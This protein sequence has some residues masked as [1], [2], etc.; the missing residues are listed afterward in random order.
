MS[1]IGSNWKK[2]LVYNALYRMDESLRMIGIS[3]EQLDEQ[4]LWRRPNGASNSVANLLLHLCGNIRQ[5]II[6][7]LG[8]AADVR[9]RDMEF[10]QTGEK[11]AAELLEQL[12]SVI[13]EAKSVISET[14]EDEFLRIREVQGFNMSGLG[15][16][17]HVV[18]HLSYHTGQ[19]AFW[20]KLLKGRDL[21]FYDGIDL[22]IKNN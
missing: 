9:L 20:T 1:Q 22:N 18:E 12:T 6:S 5:Y 11:T 2:E 8:G 17:L 3:L 19:I 4:D 21:G 16:V 10:S 7:S 14:S 15:V 13:E